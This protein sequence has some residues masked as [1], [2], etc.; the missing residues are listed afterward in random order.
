MLGECKGKGSERSM[1]LLIWTFLFLSPSL[2]SSLSL[3]LFL[4]LSLSLSLFTSAILPELESLRSAGEFVSSKLHAI[5]M[6][7]FKT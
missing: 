1:V 5:A 2:P 6:D 7:H 4:S 3:S